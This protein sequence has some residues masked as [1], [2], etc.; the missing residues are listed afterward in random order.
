MKE[1]GCGWVILDILL[2]L[3][4]VLNVLAV[5]ADPSD[6]LLVGIAALYLVYF[7]IKKI[8]EEIQVQKRLKQMRE[9][10]AREK[11]N[12]GTVEKHG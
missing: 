11:E 9:E 2:L 3:G 1:Y 6:Y 10:R 8:Y 5:G 12:G 7:I 4:A